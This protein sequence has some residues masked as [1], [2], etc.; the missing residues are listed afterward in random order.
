MN[1]DQATPVSF[2]SWHIPAGPWRWL[3][4]VLLTG[5]AATA[6]GAGLV[7]ETVR[8]NGRGITPREAIQDALVEAVS[9]VNGTSI[10]AR[11]LRTQL[12]ARGI[13]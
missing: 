10:E 8:A 2:N 6:L 13:R 1:Y 4:C 3:G 7:Y 5:F 9:Q 11:Q 12:L